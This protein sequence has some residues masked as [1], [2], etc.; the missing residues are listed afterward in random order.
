MSQFSLPGI[1]VTAD[2][3]FARDMSVALME[4]ANSM[5]QRPEA[6]S[7]IIKYSVRRGGIAGFFGATRTVTERRLK[8]GAQQWLDNASMLEQQASYFE[9]LSRSLQGLKDRQAS[10]E[11]GMTAEEQAA[12]GIQRPVGEGGQQYTRN[13]LSRPD[14]TRLA[15]LLGY[16]DRQRNMAGITINPGGT[17]GGLRIPTGT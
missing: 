13:D 8:P 11:A 1:P 10:L 2:P 14:N 17:L 16:D 9:G 7:E 15:V 5:R 4:Q 6:Q 12:L 3:G